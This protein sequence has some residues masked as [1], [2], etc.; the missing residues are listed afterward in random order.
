MRLS[1]KMLTASA[2]FLECAE[3][4]LSVP[5][6]NAKQ[7]N[8]LKEIIDGCRD[9][10]KD[11]QQMLSKYGK[12]GSDPRGLGEKMKILWKRVR[13][14]QK[15]INEL[16]SRITTNVAFLDLFTRNKIQEVKSS[17]DQFYKKQDIRELNEESS[18][19]LNWLSRINHT[20]QQQD[21][22]KK[23]H[24]GT[25][26]WLLES[27][28]FNTW[29]ASDK[30]ILFCPGIPG[31]GKTI[32]TSIVVEEL[33]N[34]FENDKSIGIAYLYCNFRRKHEQN[35]DDL[36]SCL[37][38]QLAQRLPSLPDAVKDLHKR[39]SYK[40]TSPSLEDLLQTLQSV[41][42]I[43]SKVFIFVD[44]LDE[45]QDTTGYEMKFLSQILNLQARCQLSLFA[46]SRHVPEICKKFDPSTWLEIRASDEDVE[47]YL[48]G[49]MSQISR[50]VSEKPDL[51]GEIKTA[52]I[53]AV[54]G[55]YV[56]PVNLVDDSYISVRF[57][58]AQLHLNSLRGKTS[59]KKIQQALQKLPTGSDA[60]D[61]AYTEAMER[62][63]GQLED[64]KELAKQQAIAVEIDEPELDKE[65]F[66]A[67]DQMVSV[68]AGLVT[69]DE[70]SNVIGLVHYTTQ[71]YF[72]RKQNYWFP[73]AETY[74]TTICV[75]NDFTYIH[76]LSM[77]HGIGGIMLRIQD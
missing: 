37:L 54:D 19:I 53:N 45:C 13:W 24:Q 16:R 4:E 68:C 55:M 51:Q 10:L 36:V 20:P 43:Y 66:A 17:A 41:T 2:L 69:V 33:T 58:L 49:H 8:E 48:D 46:T 61:S 26:K 7:K 42:A 50:Y 11:L 5:D 3:N 71:E 18:K 60:Y 47:R 70:E 44:A 67:I 77:P 14:D 27:Q 39:H 73:D 28:K 40:G 23:R 12:L 1:P 32:L 35:V 65:N 72:N 74:I 38:K 29:V 56:T 25:G 59:P 9:V 15:D 21:Y 22:I 34:R 62:I 76:S 57:L 30:Q 52:I 64:E 31:A 75:T 6:L 63:E